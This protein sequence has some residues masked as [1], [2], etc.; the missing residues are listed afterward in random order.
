VIYSCEIKKNIHFF[1]RFG[2]IRPGEG[3]LFKIMGYMNYAISLA[4][5][6]INKFYPKIIPS[7]YYEEKLLLLTYYLS[8]CLSWSFV[9]KRFVR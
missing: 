8:T 2:D 5:R 6:K 1:V 4:G 7:S 9:L 3:N